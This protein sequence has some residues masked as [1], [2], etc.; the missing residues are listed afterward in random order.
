MNI[1]EE[2]IHYQN[3]LLHMKVW[4]FTSNMAPSAKPPADWTWHYHKE[5]EFLFIR[6]GIHGMHTLNRSYI[7]NPG[8]VMVI[9][10]S[11]P[12]WGNK[13]SEEDL[14]YI[15][16]HVDLQPY[17]DPPMMMYYPHFSEVKSPLEALNDMFREDD[18]LREEVAGF[19]VRVHEEIM[20][21]KKGYEIAA[22]IYIRQ[23]LLSMLRGDQK[24]LLQANDAESS[25][26]LRP[27]LEYVER[28]LHE[29]ITLE[30]V[31]KLAK[32][33]YFYFSKF[34]KKTTGLT[35]TEYMNRK[36]IFRAEQ[37]L[38]TTG[39]TITEIAETVG[40]E[41]MTHFY[42]LFK[43]YTGSTPKQFLSKMHAEDE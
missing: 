24:E 38:L 5:V 20:E 34:F 13:L 32:M 37:L 18:S 30:E 14:V 31:S 19:I 21:R 41:N 12:H 15:V 1:Y 39:L 4:E 7:L 42:Q 17:F 11:Q 27:I 43:R 22:S 36:R 2:P 23:I 40:I 28:H 6:S 29:R 8:D 10:A 26:I 9:G 16:L 33:S 25:I 3:P 35:F